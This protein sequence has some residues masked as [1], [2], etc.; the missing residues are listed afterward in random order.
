MKEIWKPIVGYEG[1]YEVSN[2]GK[3]ASLH[4][5]HSNRRVIMKPFYQMG[6]L[7]IN[8]NKDGS[9]K[10][11]LVH[12][13]VATAFV[14]NKNNLTEVDHINGIK[15][16]NKA[17]N[18]RWSTRVENINNPNTKDN[19]R[20]FGKSNHFYGKHHS[21]MTRKFISDHNS[22]SVIQ[23]S[24]SG[25]FIREWS[26]MIAVERELGIQTGRV[27]SCCK[28]KPHYNTAGGFIWR[29]KNEN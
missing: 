2:L 10:K 14:D 17:S 9:R 15:N 8:L 28:R 22:I 3:I 16:D 27:S 13:L 5:R 25:E 12:Q 1:L 4:Y 18:L 6:Y 23:L 24:K 21:I 20:H 26:S 29:Y 11:Y 19:F 7:R